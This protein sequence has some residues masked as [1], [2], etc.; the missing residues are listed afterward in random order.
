M[1]MHNIYKLKEQAKEEAY[2]YF[3]KNIHPLPKDSLGNIDETGDG[4]VDN[5]IDA[6]RHAYV[7]GVFVQELNANQAAFW[8]WLNEVFPS[9]G[10]GSQNSEAA[11]NMD[12]WNNAV[13][14]KYGKI[15]KS[16]KELAELLK[17]ALERGELIISL[18]DSRIYSGNFDFQFD[19]NRPVIVI[20]ESETGRNELFCDLSTG[21][22][23]E[24][25][26]FVLAIKNGTYPGYVIASIDGVA[27]PMSKSDGIVSNN[28]G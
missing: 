12:Y 15:A 26:I 4:F 14:R 24:R 23:F 27:T 25:E 9:S 3:D 19:P 6:F 20:H 8:G 21:E 17:K 2:A 18:D 10:S 1:Q 13:G 28:L 16:R 22:I 7:S 11:K 5:D